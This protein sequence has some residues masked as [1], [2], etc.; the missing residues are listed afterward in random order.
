MDDSPVFDPWLLR[1]VPLSVRGDARVA[2]RCLLRTDQPAA[3]WLIQ[4]TQS[5]AADNPEIYVAGELMQI[6]ERI[7]YSW[8]RLNKTQGLN[9]AQHLI[10]SAWMSRHTDGC[11]RQ[12]GLGHLLAS[13]AP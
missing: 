11:V 10:L 8:P 13:D 12:R 2:M 4:D 1:S 5:H 6:P 3:R 9:Q 7:H